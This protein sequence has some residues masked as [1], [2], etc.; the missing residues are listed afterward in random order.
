M[1]KLIILFYLINFSSLSPPLYIS[2]NVENSVYLLKNNSSGDIYCEMVKELYM[3]A[4]LYLEK[5]AHIESKNSVVKEIFINLIH[6]IWDNTSEKMKL[7]SS[8][9]EKN[10]SKTI[11]YLV[12]TLGVTNPLD[13][14]DWYE[15]VFILI[16]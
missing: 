8:N 14:S 5:A 11:E 1:T 16:A 6:L 4:D 3:I 10:S 2:R 9:F 12:R 7:N 15:I 13:F